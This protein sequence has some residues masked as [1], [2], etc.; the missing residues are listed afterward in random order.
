MADA[1]LLEKMLAAGEESATM[2]GVISELA[3]LHGRWLQ[4]RDAASPADELYLA[5]LA[6]HAPLEPYEVAL[7]TAIAERYPVGATHIVEIGSGWGGLA[8]LLA[9]LG[10]N[11]T[12]YEGNGARHAGCSWHVAQQSPALRKRL[13]LVDP[14]LFPEALRDAHVTADKLNI[15]IATT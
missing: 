5:K 12:G 9:R 4:T 14:G 8:I 11:V 7:A 2:Q 10:F 13:R 3:D 1:P 6:N 15:C